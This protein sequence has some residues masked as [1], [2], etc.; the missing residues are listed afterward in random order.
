M[1]WLYIY[2]VEICVLVINVNIKVD[3]VW[4]GEGFV[5]LNQICID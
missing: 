5:K 1:K 3:K 2:L 4:M